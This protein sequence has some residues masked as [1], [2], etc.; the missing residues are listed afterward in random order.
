MRY[1]YL[2]DRFTDPTLIDA[3]CDPIR[4]DDGKC[5]IGRNATQLVRFAGGREV[6]VLRRRLRLTPESR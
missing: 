4:R 3:Y 5:I 1:Y 2:G 6:I